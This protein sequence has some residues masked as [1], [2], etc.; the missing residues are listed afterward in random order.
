M[1]LAF[2]LEARDGGARLGRFRTG[3]GVV[4]TPTFMPVGTQGSV[5]AV[6]PRDLEALGAEVVLGNTY[7]LYLRP[8]HRV[9]AEL[10]GLHRFMAWDRPILTDSGGYQVLSL[11]GLSQV[12][13]EGVRFRSHL[14][15]SSHLLTPELAMEVQD[16]LD[17]DIAMPL[18][19]CPPAGAPLAEVEEAVTRSIRWLERCKKAR[20]RPDQQ[21]LFGIVQGGTDPELR[22]RSAAATVALDL[23]G[24]AV[25][26]LAVGE[27]KALTFDTV[28]RVTREL[29]AD[30]PRYLMGMG[31][32]QDLVEGVARGIDMFDSVLPTRN[33]RN[34]A[35]FTSAGRVNI[36]NARYRSDPRP[37]DPAC[38]CYTC[39]RFSRGYLRHLYH[40]GEVL[41]PVLLTLHNLTYYLDTMER[42]RQSIAARRFEELRREIRA[43]PGASDAD[44]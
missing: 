14:D 1:D 4:R 44:S 42:I 17:S 25:G 22:R 28:E 27:D 37:L 12:S 20:V 35:L 41:A 31:T 38:R 36:R 10:G 43:I 18:D 9:V 8:G 16:A 30:R 24:Y 23:D 15:G 19:I 11:Q 32:P 6:L 7:H 5:K 39:T 3:H 40:A 29:P 21:A 2:A 13:E 26:G 34:A 33:A